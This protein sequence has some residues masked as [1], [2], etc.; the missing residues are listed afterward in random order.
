MKT[1]NYVHKNLPKTGT[2]IHVQKT[3]KHSPRYK[4]KEKYKKEIT[5]Y[6]YRE[7]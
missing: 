7:E 4:Q 2:G 3:G 1:R 6:F 5:R